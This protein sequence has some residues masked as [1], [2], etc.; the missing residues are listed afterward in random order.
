LFTF[1]HG[2][3]ARKD[4][5]V[6]A[7]IEA[8]APFAK[9]ILR[10]V[11]KLVLRACPDVQETIKWSFPHFEHKGIL[12]GMAAFKGH[13]ALGFWK[14]QLIFGTG[15]A[16]GT[17]PVNWSRRIQSISDLPPDHELMGYIRKAAELNES[18]TRVPKRAAAKKPP[19]R[20]PKDL[21]AALKKNGR[22]K[23]TFANL[24]PS[25]KREYVEWIVGA[26]RDETRQRR[27]KTTVE[28]LSQGKPHNWRYLK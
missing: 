7:Y 1:D 24:S 27:L 14:R 25:C 21:S 18:D 10:H 8:A 4:P 2:D 13:C 17:E 15:E 22:A 9:P 23:K 16:E 20:M 3:M 11:R 12:C 19:P 5:R 6:D 26:K 28:W